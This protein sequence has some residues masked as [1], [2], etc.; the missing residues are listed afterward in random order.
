MGFDNLTLSGP[1]GKSLKGGVT[2]T[3]ALKTTETENLRLMPAKVVDCR[4]SFGVP[5]Q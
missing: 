4:F 1:D 2:G 5:V 3:L